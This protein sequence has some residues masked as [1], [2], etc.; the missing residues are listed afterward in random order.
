MSR[1][2]STVTVN[3][4]IAVLKEGKA[5]LGPFRLPTARTRHCEVMSVDVYQYCI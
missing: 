2:E 3:R 4:K 1:R 5:G